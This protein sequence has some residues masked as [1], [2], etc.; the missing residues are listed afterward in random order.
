MQRLLAG[1]PHSIVLED[2]SGQL[3]VL[4]S[5]GARVFKGGGCEGGAGAVGG[6]FDSTVVLDRGDAAWLANLGQVRHYLYP[7]HISKRF[8]IVPSLAS[9]LSL[10]SFKFLHRSYAD[11]ARLAASCVTDTSLTS[12]EAQLW[13]QL[14]F[15][16]DDVHPDAVGCRLQIARKMAGLSVCVPFN[17]AR[18]LATYVRL[19]HSVS[20]ACRLSVQEEMELL[21]EYGQQ[22]REL[23][24]RTAMLKLISK[25]PPSQGLQLKVEHHHGARKQDAEFDEIE[26][27]T[28]LEGAEGLK[29][30]VGGVSLASYTP[31]EQG[32]GSKIAHSLNALVETLSL[33]GIP[34]GKNLNL[35]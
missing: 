23:R 14:A 34:T 3:F 24:N 28:C 5:A 21:E 20:S 2:V 30:L 31:P 8:L 9:A 32:Y 17:I 13:D 27:R 16:T 7:V 29:T 4:A 26:D 25:S 15:M 1:M 6:D 33:T 10:L 22:T 11:A 35:N 18:D 12:E 19:L